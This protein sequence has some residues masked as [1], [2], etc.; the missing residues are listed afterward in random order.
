MQHKTL[1]ILTLAGVCPL[2]LSV[3]PTLTAQQLERAMREGAAMNTPSS[4]YNLRDYLLREYNSGVSL[5]PRAGEV[6]AVTVATPY[7]RVRY[8]SYLE[9]LQQ[10]PMNVAKARE[11]LRQ[12]QGRVTFVVFAHSPFTVDAETEQ[13]MQA[14]G[15]TSTRGERGETRTRSFL[16]R[17]KPATLS[18]GGRTYTARP[19]ADG[20]YTDIFS[21]LGSRPESRYL[22]LLSYSFD[23]SRLGTRESIGGRG[24]LRFRDSQ[25]QTEYRLEVDLA[26]YF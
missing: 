20:P 5:T 2:A 7:E 21:I 13:F 18:L 3:Q 10:S 26:K 9:S 16:D 4:G 11:V 14:Y 24:V 15:S 25:G 6:D 1:L 23:L 22:G 19:V 12:Y 17:Y 8:H